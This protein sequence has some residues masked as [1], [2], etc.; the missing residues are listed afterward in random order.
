MTSVHFI[1]DGSIVVSGSH[2][3]SCGIWDVATGACLKVHVE[4][5][6]PKPAVS[7]AKFSPNGKFVLVAALDST[8]VY[9]LWPLFVC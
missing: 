8:L 7:F 5:K 4:D 2:D 3:G 9:T 6:V 1:R